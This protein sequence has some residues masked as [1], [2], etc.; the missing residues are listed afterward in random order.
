MTP[1]N[2]PD[3]LKTLAPEAWDQLYAVVVS[4]Y[5]E[6]N[7]GEIVASEKKT[8]A[9]LEFPRWSYTEKVSDFVKMVYSM[10]IVLAFDWL[11][12]KEGQAMLDKPEQDFSMLDTVTLCKLLTLIVRAERYY[13]GYLNK[14][15]ENRSVLKITEALT[16]G[17]N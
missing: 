2:L 12:W 4:I 15:F 10:N 13:E 14:C 1:E 7:F 9:Y 17:G 6:N 3:H 8:E 11:Q 16:K 5:N